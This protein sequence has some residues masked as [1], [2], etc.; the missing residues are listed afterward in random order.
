MRIIAQAEGSVLVII[1]VAGLNHPPPVTRRLWQRIE[2]Q[3]AKP[4]E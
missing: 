3:L 1:E 2:E 4:N